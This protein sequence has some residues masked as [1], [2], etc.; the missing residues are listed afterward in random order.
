MGR[1]E[2]ETIDVAKLIYPP[3]Q[4]ADIFM[5]EINLAHSGLDQRKAHVI[6]RDVANKLKFKP[7]K[8][9][10]KII[11]P[12][13]VHHHLILGV[14]KPVIWPVPKEKMQ[15]LWSSMKMS[16]SDPS[17]AVFIHDSEDEIRKKLNEAFCPLGELEF[18]P[19]LDWCNSLIFQNTSS[20][21]VEREPKFGGDITYNSYKELENDF[22]NN[23]L[24]PKDLKSATAESLIKL[25]KPAR[26]HFKKAKVDSMKKELENLK[27]TK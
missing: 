27:I 22:K 8:H 14:K 20:L 3:M 11:K 21:K 12:L 26:N 13:A 17:S 9:E 19:V 25:L 15:D 6:A 5:Q 16:K 23:K 2:G 18:N 1:K 4:V 24:H 10:N 7:L